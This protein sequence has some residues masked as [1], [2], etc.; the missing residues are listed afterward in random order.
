[1][2]LNFGFLDIPYVNKPESLYSLV[3]SPKLTKRGK[4]S[5]RFIRNLDKAQSITQHQETRAK[6]T[7]EVADFLEKYGVLEAFIERY[8]EQIGDI[9]GERIVEKIEEVVLGEEP[10]PLGGVKYIPAISDMFVKFIQ[11]REMD[12]M[13]GVPTQAAIDEGRPSFYDTGNYANSMVAWFS[14]DD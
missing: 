4:I 10:A 1:M 8:S 3:N 2:I 5:K 7:A 13:S 9:I 11:N 12:G 14:E 6:T